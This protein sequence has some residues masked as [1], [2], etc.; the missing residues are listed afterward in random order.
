[1]LE[2]QLPEGLS[3]RFGVEHAVLAELVEGARK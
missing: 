2:M 3:D 1:M